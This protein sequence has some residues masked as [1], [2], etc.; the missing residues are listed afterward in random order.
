M[1]TTTTPLPLAASKER[2]GFEERSELGA[3]GPCL[4]VHRVPGDSPVLPP[5]LSRALPLLLHEFDRQE[6]LAPV[7][8]QFNALAREGG[9]GRPSTKMLLQRI[10]PRLVSYRFAEAR[11]V[12]EFLFEGSRAS[13]V[14]V[15]ARVLETDYAFR[16]EDLSHFATHGEH[17]LGVLN[18]VGLKQALDPEG[19]L[20]CPALDSPFPFK[21]AV[22]GSSGRSNRDVY[23]GMLRELLRRT[24][25]DEDFRARTFR[26]L[27]RGFEK[28]GPAAATPR[29]QEVELRIWRLLTY[30]AARLRVKAGRLTDTRD[31]SEVRQFLVE[32]RQV[33]TALDHLAH[34]PGRLA[35]LFRRRF[36]LE[37]SELA[38]QAL[39]ELDAIAARIDC[40]LERPL[41]IDEKAALLSEMRRLGSAA[42]LESLALQDRGLKQAYGDVEVP[43]LDVEVRTYTEVIFTGAERFDTRRYDKGALDHEGLGGLLSES[44][45]D[46]DV[47]LSFGGEGDEEGDEE[48]EADEEAYGDAEDLDEDEGDWESDID[49]AWD[50]D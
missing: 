8:E 20:Y 1:A 41:S 43:P 6:G 5:E 48:L 19:T 3:H 13:S 18:A 34:L 29:F 2:W 26:E 49:S 33:H 47:S 25:K 15:L 38:E 44:D 4:L 28:F 30:L 40:E 10:L 17:L 45:F 32:L 31:L 36:D 35:A 50:V 22:V 42:P 21:F 9:V 14:H 24:E 7:L 27:T 39:P 12:R 16:L 46:L 23:V 37:L 11:G